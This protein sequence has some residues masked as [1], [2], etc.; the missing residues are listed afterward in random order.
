MTLA[1]AGR[2][3]PGGVRETSLARSL[4]TQQAVEHG[5][6]SVRRDAHYVY[7]LGRADRAGPL[8]LLLQTALSARQLK[9][10]VGLCKMVCC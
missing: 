3:P 4:R 5:W 9:H 2:H 10:S 6:L 8:R 1:L 7:T